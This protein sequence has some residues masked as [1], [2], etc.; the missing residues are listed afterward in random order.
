MAVSRVTLKAD[1]LADHHSCRLGKWYYGEG[2]CAMH[3]H[4]AFAA[5]EKPHAGSYAANAP[6]NSSSR[7][8]PA[9]SRKS[10]KWKRRRRMSCGCSASLV[11]EHDPEKWKPVF[12]QDHAQAEK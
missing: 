1:E 2:S 11:A 12:G 6:R 4:P 7:A 3:G 9:R 8:T 10:R 5:L